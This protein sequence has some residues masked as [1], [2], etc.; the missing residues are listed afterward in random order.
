MRAVSISLPRSCRSNGFGCSLGRRGRTSKGRRRGTLFFY[1]LNGEWKQTVIDDVRTHIYHL[2]VTGLVTLF[3]S[4]VYSLVAPLSRLVAL[5]MEV[6][7]AGHDLFIYFLKGEW[8]RASSE[9]VT[10][11]N[12]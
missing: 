1:F 6:A 12:W 3:P 5:G 11:F 7:V 10:L 2:F 9:D 8:K 4:L